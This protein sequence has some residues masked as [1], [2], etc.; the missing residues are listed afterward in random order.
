M[1]K[2]ITKKLKYYDKNKKS[3]YLLY[4]DNNLYGWRMSQKLSVNNFEG[5]ED[6]SQYNE[7]FIKTIIKKVMSSFS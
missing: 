4:W 7:D 6:I 1:Q 2:L 5:I 3:S